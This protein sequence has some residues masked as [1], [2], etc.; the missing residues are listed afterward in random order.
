[1]LC[2]ICKKNPAVIFFNKK[3]EN[4]NQKVEGYCLE[5][6]Q[7]QGINTIQNLNLSEK[8]LNNMSK[9]IENIVSNLA[10]NIDMDNISEQIED[11]SPEDTEKFEEGSP[12]Q[13]GAAI[14]LGSIFSNMFG[15]NSASSSDDNNSSEKKKVK[16][17][18]KKDKRKKALEAYGTNLT[19]KAKNGQLD[20]IIGRD[21]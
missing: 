10:Q 12:I 19:L 2:S 6:A 5:C 1:M 4:G 16:V 11:M 18:K 14:P 13:F 20:M 3:D 15:S 9:Q 17:D 7:K 21:R 8:D